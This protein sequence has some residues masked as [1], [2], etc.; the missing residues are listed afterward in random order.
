M[1]QLSHPRAGVPLLD[2]GQGDLP[3]IDEPLE[4]FQ[5]QDSW[6]PPS[7][8]AVSAEMIR[9][10]TDALWRCCDGAHAGVRRWRR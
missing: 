9:Q 8:Q 7:R 3:A 10:G 5:M 2:T 4:N 6:V 1:L